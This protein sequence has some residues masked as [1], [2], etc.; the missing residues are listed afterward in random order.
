MLD[1]QTKLIQHQIA[2]DK[3]IFGESN[4]E[5]S[6]SGSSRR[7]FIGLSLNQTVKELIMK[8]EG[9]RAEKLKKE[10]VIPDRR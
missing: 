1:D 9:K 2:F 7:S 5:T 8:N 6:V 4:P 10:F 3:E